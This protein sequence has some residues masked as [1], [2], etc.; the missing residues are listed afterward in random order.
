MVTEEG[1]IL[2]ICQEGE[3]I[4][5]FSGELKQKTHVECIVKEWQSDL[6][7]EEY[8]VVDPLYFMIFL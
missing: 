7:I 3:R 5:I 1:N 4:M 8:L 2:L 6:I